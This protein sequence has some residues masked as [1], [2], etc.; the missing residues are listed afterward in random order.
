MATQQDSL[1]FTS[2]RERAAAQTILQNQVN[3]SVISIHAV[4]K[5]VDLTSIQPKAAA[6][7]AAVNNFKAK[8]GEVLPI[9]DAD[10]SL[11]AVLL[12]LGDAGQAS[13]HSD[14]AQLCWAYAALPGK[15]PAGT[16]ALASTTAGTNDADQALLG[17]MLGTWIHVILGTR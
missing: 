5:G 15:V 13:A 9:P 4:S 6:S 7:W 16:Y 12:G 3:G 10:G 2:S 17:W 1:L 14:P 8:A 11:A